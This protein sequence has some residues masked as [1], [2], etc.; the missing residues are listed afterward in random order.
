MALLLRKNKAQLAELVSWLE[1]KWRSKGFSRVELFRF[2]SI[3]PYPSVGSDSTRNR[4]PWS[5]TVKWVV[6]RPQ[7]LQGLLGLI[8]RLGY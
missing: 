1:S 3:N 6:K 7:D 4:V 5:V 8:T 2:G